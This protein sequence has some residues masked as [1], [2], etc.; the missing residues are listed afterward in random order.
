MFTMHATSMIFLFACRWRPPSATTCSLQVGARDV[1]SAHQRLRLRRS[2]RRPVRQHVVLPAA[3]P[4]VGSCMP[5]LQ[6]AAPQ[7]RHQHLGARLD[8]HRHRTSQSGDQLI[9]TALNMRTKGMSLMRMPVF[10][11]MVPSS[12]SAVFTHPGDH[13][14]SGPA[15]VGASSATFFSV[16][17][18]AD[19][20][21]W[22]HCSDRH[23][24][25]TS[26]FL[27]SFGYVPGSAGL[28]HKPLFGSR[29]SS[30]PAPPSASSAGGSG[31]TTCSP[32]A[33]GR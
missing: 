31:P 32:L 22:Q 24:R 4:A 33:S 19:P 16:A 21:L 18:G 27:P 1:A 6:R 20:L 11:W 13:G 9:V 12:S 10:T 5:E 2:L 15:A 23:P 3:P 25:C 7:Q 26:S 14:G 28:L 29:S 30:S 17:A 8:H